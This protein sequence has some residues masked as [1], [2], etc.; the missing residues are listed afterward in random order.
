MNLSAKHALIRYTIFTVLASLLSLWFLYQIRNILVMLFISFILMSAIYP[1][2]AKAQNLKI[3]RSLT[4]FSV[5]LLI[6]IFF[7]GV[8]ASLTPIIVDQTTGLIDH[9]PYILNFLEQHYHLKIDLPFLTQNLRSLPTNL[10]KLVTGVFS[11]TF[12]IFAIFFLTYYLILER[13]KLHQHLLIFFGHN[14][15][16]KKAEKFIRDLEQKIGH[17]ASGQFLLMLIIG[18]ATYFGLLLL[19]MPYALPLALLAGLLEAV[20]NIGPTIS[21][22]VSVLVGL[23]VS[24]LT[25]LGAL[26]LGVVIQQL[27]NNLIVPQVMHFAVGLSPIVTLVVLLIGLELGGVIGAVLAIPS[28]LAFTTIFEYQQKGGRHVSDRSD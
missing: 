8:I 1:L 14:Q 16:E 17:W 11:N 19:R 27:E 6:I 2:V 28:Y 4:V 24:P 15:T 13:E 26:V 25:A 18:S 3:P 10:F 9:L 22:F 20:P 7:F 21:A 23:T 12:N 5:Y